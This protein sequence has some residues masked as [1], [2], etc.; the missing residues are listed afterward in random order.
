MASAAL[1]WDNMSFLPALSL[2]SVACFAPLAVARL[3]M[4]SFAPTAI[5]AIV[6]SFRRKML[7]VA[8]TTFEVQCV[9]LALCMTLALSFLMSLCYSIC[10]LALCMAC[11]TMSAALSLCSKSKLFTLSVTL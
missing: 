1:W 2:A 8:R 5:P 7:P 6:S 3:M 4:M 11:A 9:F 10:Y